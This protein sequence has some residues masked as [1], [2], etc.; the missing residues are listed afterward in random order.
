MISFILPAS[1]AVW[2]GGPAGGLAVPARPLHCYLRSGAVKPRHGRQGRGIAMFGG[3]VCGQPGVGRFFCRANHDQ[4]EVRRWHRSHP[5]LWSSG[6]RTGAW[7]QRKTQREIGIGAQ[8][9]SDLNLKRIRILTN[10]PRKVP[11][12]EG[13]GIEIVEQV[14]VSAT[15]KA[16]VR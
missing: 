11:G 8:I 6:S 13:F 12:L 14:P 7:T 4:L 16:T 9:L 2:S 3:P 10:H 1:S 5:R 15:G